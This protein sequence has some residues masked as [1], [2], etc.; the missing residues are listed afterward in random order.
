M[1]RIPPRLWVTCRVLANETRL[2]LLNEIFTTPRQSVGDLSDV[3]GLSLG[4]TSNQLKILCSEGF[5]TLHRQKQQVRYDDIIPYAPNHIK[6][7]QIAVRKEF[8]RNADRQS[9]YKEATGLTHQ[10][11]IELLHRI[12]QSPHSMEQLLTKTV[13]SYSALSRHLHKLISRNYVSYSNRQYR[14]GKPGGYLAKAL[15]KIIRDPDAG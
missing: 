2:N 11:R 9:I 13:M 14:L 15:I 4:A 5:I 10:R 6:R 1:K 12:S 8:K 7:L 3:I